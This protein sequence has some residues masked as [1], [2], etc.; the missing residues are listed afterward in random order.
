MN[1]HIERMSYYHWIVEFLPKLRAVEVYDAET[2]EEIS[3]ILEPDAP[4]W[5]VEQ[6]ALAGIP[7]TRLRWLPETGA[8][9]DRLVYPTHRFRS[10]HN[11]NPSTSQL[12][13]VRRRFRKAIE[14]D[15]G[16]RDLRIFLSRGDAQNRR[17]RNRDELET[18]LAHY[19]FECVQLADLSEAEGIRLFANA[20]FVI[21]PH[22][23]GLAN[24]LFSKNLTPFEMFP[25][26][27]ID[28]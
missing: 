27:Y 13:W 10:G 2:A 18:M 8:T 9:F 12:R 1:G 15:D 5:Q 25:S 26:D 6:L 17:V 22:G 3:I 16:K 23:A 21:G 11:Y 19:G 28:Q 20:D 24:I 7:E 14:A 4:D